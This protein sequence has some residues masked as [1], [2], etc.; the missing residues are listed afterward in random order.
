MKIFKDWLS[1][2]E[3]LDVRQVSKAVQNAAKTGQNATQ[4]AKQTL[5][6]KLQDPKVDVSSITKIA[7]AVDELKP[8]E[9]EKMQ[10]GQ[11]QNNNMQN[12]P[13]RRMKKK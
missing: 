13:I 5:L 3:N 12:N 9:K 4:L 6:N 11:Q 7:K 1:V 10:P 2:K 8:D